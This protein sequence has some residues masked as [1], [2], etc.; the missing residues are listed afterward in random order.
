MAEEKRLSQ[1]LERLERVIAR[2][3]VIAVERSPETFLEELSA[4]ESVIDLRKK[5]MERSRP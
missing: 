1:I 2:R 3:L 5:L 4:L